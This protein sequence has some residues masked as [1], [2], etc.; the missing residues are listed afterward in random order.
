MEMIIM[1]AII[2]LGAFLAMSAYALY[3]NNNWADEYGKLNKEWFEI[4]TGHSKDWA[5]YCQKLAVE[6][7]ALNARVKELEAELAEKE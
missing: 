2:C 3:I 6:C 1:F 4:S 7:D 5:D